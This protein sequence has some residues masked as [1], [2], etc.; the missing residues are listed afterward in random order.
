MVEFLSGGQQA[1]NTLHENAIGWMIMLVVLG[2]LVWLFWYYKAEEVRN[3]VRWIR[4][5]EMWFLSWFIELGTI[6]GLHGDEGYKVLHNGQMVDW[7][8]YFEATPKWSKAQLNL[9]HMTLFTSLT[10]QPLK[11]VYVAIAALG[12]L[13][14][15]FNGPRTHYRSRMGLEGLIDRQ[16]KNF[17]VIAP[18]AN[19]NPATQPPRPPGSPVPVEL[20][21]FAEALGPEEWLA[22]CNI[23]APDGKLD[24]DAAAKSFQKQLYGR[25]KGA[26]ALKPYQQVLLAAFCL[27]ASRKRDECDDILGRLALC[28]APK[29]G[30]RLSRDKG[31]LKEARKILKNKN[32]A[33]K[34]LSK[35]NQHAFVATAMLRALATAREEG[36][37]LAPAQFVWL[38]GHDRTLWY[39]LNNMGRQSF[40]ME[41]IGA[42]SHYKAEKM[43][44]RPIPVPKVEYAVQTITEYMS[45]SRARPIPQLDYSQS[46]KRGVKKAI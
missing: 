1:E 32:L 29:G 38:R 5:G 21:Q 3:I 35:C 34:T 28:W 9:G 37:V 27:K 8:T 40:H 17:P 46:K 10:M 42:M 19:F 24:Q 39:P 22:Y 16:A 23:P 2:V 11:L 31:L 43:T 12:A 45:S 14:C 36:G 26:M 7:Q 33:G 6:L 20:P 13:W 15:I 18:F 41:A 44:Q 30:L 4:Y 25:W